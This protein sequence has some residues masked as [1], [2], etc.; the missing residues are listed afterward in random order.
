MLSPARRQPLGLEYASD[1]CVH[2]LRM[3]PLLRTPPQQ[4]VKL[5]GPAPPVALP[6]FGELQHAS[7][8]RPQRGSLA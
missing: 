5:A 1:P 2:K 3:K 4:I 8:D 6:P 7:R